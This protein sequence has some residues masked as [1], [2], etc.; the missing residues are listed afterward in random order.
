VLDEVAMVLGDELRDYRNLFTGDIPA[1]EAFSRFTVVV[2]YRLRASGTETR[3]MTV[4]R[5]LPR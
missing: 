2:V 3:S 1:V 4:I 5:S